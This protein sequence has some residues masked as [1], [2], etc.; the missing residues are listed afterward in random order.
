MGESQ[1]GRRYGYISETRMCAGYDAKNIGICPVSI[2]TLVLAIKT[3]GVGTKCSYVASIR[4]PLVDK[5]V[6]RTYCKSTTFS[7]HLIFTLFANKTN[8]LK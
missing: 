5:F 8:S 3:F 2:Y 7:Y 4:M 6:K 1:C